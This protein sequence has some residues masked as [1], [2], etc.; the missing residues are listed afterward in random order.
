MKIDKYFAIK[1]SLERILIAILFLLS[2][3][4]TFL[5]IK[6]NLE[7][8]QLKSDLAIQRTQNKNLEST[9]EDVESQ[10]SDLEGKIDDIEG[11]VDDLESN[12]HSHYY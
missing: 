8:N 6:Q 5:F 11:R 12:S 9:I 3:I 10:N 1:L 2:I 4:F 7:I